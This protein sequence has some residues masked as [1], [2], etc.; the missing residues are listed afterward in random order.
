[1]SFVALL[2]AG[3]VVMT[4]L[5]VTEGRQLYKEL[6]E[7]LDCLLAMLAFAL[8]LIF[9]FVFISQLYWLPAELAAGVCHL[10]SFKF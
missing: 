10:M 1:M 4:E 9:L 3:H 6:A 2:Q 8:M 7:Q 5:N